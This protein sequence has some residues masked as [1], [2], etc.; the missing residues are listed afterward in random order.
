MPSRKIKLSQIQ[1]HFLLFISFIK[2]FFI[3][4]LLLVGA[5][6]IFLFLYK[7]SSQEVVVG[8]NID[9]VESYIPFN[10]EAYYQY[11]R[12]ANT[13][14]PRNKKGLIDLRGGFAHNN[15]IDAFRHSFVSGAF[16]QKYGVFVARILGD[17][18]ELYDDI[19]YNQS[20]QEKNM[21]KWNNSFG[22]RVGLK[23]ANLNQLAER[24]RT[25]IDNKELI[26]N[27]ND[28]RKYY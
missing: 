15:Q 5:S 25:A 4:F 13:S 1:S 26:V 10:S 22:R 18:K 21:D 12:V 27:I 14:L 3:L 7:N 11:E 20:L 6:L 9:V 17:I 19:F 24:L 23:T 28:K 8:S 2:Y 16:T